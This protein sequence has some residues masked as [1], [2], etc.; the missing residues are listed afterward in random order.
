MTIKNWVW[1]FCFFSLITFMLTVYFLGLLTPD[2][3]HYSDTISELTIKKYGWIQQ[4]NFVQLGI[5]LSV[6]SYLFLCK[7]TQSDSKKVWIRIILIS[8]VI[9][10]IETIFPTDEIHNTNLFE[11]KLTIHGTIHLSALAIYFLLAPLGVYSL[12][13]IF[14][15]EPEFLELANITGILGY[16][17]SGLCYLWT[18][19]LITGLF[20]AYLGIFQKI[21]ATLTILWLM[22]L[23]LILKE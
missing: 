11:N 8:A 22:K 12:K 1:L 7:L 4:I 18:F 17:L 5:S 23:L 3:N 9:L 16:T 15:N 2:Y 6:T 13:K 19:F 20:Y 21:L 10:L 14:K